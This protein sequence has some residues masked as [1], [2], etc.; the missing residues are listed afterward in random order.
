MRDFPS[1]TMFTAT[2]LTG[3]FV[4]L[5]PSHALAQASREQPAVLR[6]LSSCRAITAADARL[7]CFD[8]AA[9]RVEA[10]IRTR[11]VTVM[12]R[13]GLRET[14]R[15]L[16]GF[17]LPRIELFGGQPGSAADEPEFTE[18]HATAKRFIPAGFGKYEL[19]LDDGSRW[20]TSEPLG[21]PPR[22]GTKV[23]IRKGT[24]GAYF[25]TVGT[26]RSVRG[27]RIG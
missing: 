20:T 4:A 9:E 7:A 21:L 16:F 1:P 10:A 6:A 19:I 22:D 23:R 14:R 5:V 18:I 3:A 26:Q 2:V 12:D 13:E 17:T 11:E 27:R 15:S 24:L 25:L 8:A